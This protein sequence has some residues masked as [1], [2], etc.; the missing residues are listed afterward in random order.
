MKRIF[1]ITWREQ[2]PGDTMV[3]TWD[4]RFLSVDGNALP[5]VNWIAENHQGTGFE[6]I[7][8]ALLGEAEKDFNAP[9]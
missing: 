1:K 3:H 9:T 7:G 5:L 8:V 4:E 2:R 6:L